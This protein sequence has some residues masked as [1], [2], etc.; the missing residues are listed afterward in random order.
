[1][2]CENKVLGKE[3]FMAP[4][5]CIKIVL[6]EN[7]ALMEIVIS[8]NPNFRTLSLRQ[9]FDLINFPLYYRIIIIII[10]IC[11][12]SSFHSLSL[13]ICFPGLRENGLA[14]YAG[15]W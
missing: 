6:V 10:P 4:P 8:P 2:E 5:I 7:V 13:P 11:S 9:V 14:R 15:H 1:M 12:K 3:I